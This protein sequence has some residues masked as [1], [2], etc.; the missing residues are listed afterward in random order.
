MTERLIL[1]QNNRLETEFLSA[2][3]HNPESAE[4]QST[5]HLYELTPYGMFLAG[6]AG[7]TSIILHTYA[8]NHGIDLQKVE[9]RLT[10]ER[11]FEED[12]EP[13]V[14]KEPYT[15]QIDEEILLVGTLDE[16]DREKLFLVSKQCPLHK[17]VE[18]G[19]EVNSYLVEEPVLEERT[20]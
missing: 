3:P 8:Q 19:T 17:I 14:E 11:L 13:C 1:R 16:R 10:Y 6:L 15:E 2:D 4:F 5:T 7:C 20:V 12:C 18:D 9:L